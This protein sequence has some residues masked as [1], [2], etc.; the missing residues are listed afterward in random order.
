[1]S[2]QISY[3]IGNALYLSIN[4]RCTLECQFCPKTKGDFHVKGYDLTMDHRPTADE[5]IASVDVPSVY[6]EVVFC[7]YG[8]PTL[9]LKTLLEVARALKAQQA[10]IRLNTDGLANL[11][12]KRNILPELSGLVDAVSVSMNAQNEPIYNRHCQPQL[13]GSYQAMLDFLKQAPEYIPK[14]TATAIRGLEGVDIAA[15][16]K[17]AEDL[18]VNFRQRELDIVG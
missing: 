1:M 6:D 16:R 8:E 17:I 3:Q 12:H 15:C 10:R 4:D 18:G 14:V 2:Q 11:V 5:I 13:P 7:G 9:R